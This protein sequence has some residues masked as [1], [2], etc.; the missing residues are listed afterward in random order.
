VMNYYHR[1][2]I[3]NHDR[4]YSN[5]VSKF[6][7]STNASPLNLQLSRDAV[8]AAGV[9][10][11]AIPKDPDTGDDL[12]TFFGHAPFFTNGTAPASDYTYSRRRLVSFNFNAY[13]EALPDSERW[14]G[15]VNFDHKICDDQLLVYG[16]FF[17]QDVK[18]NYELAPSATGN[19]QTPGNVTLAIP[20]DTPIAPGSEPPNTPTHVETGVPADAFNPFNPFHQIISGGTRARLIEFGNRVIDNETNAFFSTLGLKGDKLFNGTW[21][22]DASFHYSQV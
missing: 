20:P 10:E 22:Y 21:G 18:T 12:D 1:N 6:F 7:A 15:F 11:G 2:S 4:A 14:G 5:H 13:S 9:G 19:F 17:Y 16:D 3:F 8:L